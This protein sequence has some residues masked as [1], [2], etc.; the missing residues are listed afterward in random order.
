MTRRTLTLGLASLVLLGTV[1]G[2][3][4]S[5]WGGRDDGRLLQ[6]D[7]RALVAVGA[8]VYSEHCASCHGANLEG[9]PGWQRRKPDGKLPAPPHNE[10][11]H[12]WHHDE[13]T[14]FAITKYGTAKAANLVDY[15]SD[16]PIYDGVLTD[17]EII[18]VLSF[19]KS[20]WPAAIRER[21]DGSANN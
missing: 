11:G 20:T 13:A 15:E 9:E 14:L 6:P 16:M 4:F 10:T 17:E 21:H 12:T 2:I 3:A 5:F 1:A 7:D 8:D 19:I 18:A